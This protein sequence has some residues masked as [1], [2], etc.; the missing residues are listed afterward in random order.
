MLLNRL[1]L[2]AAN[3]YYCRTCLGRTRRHECARDRQIACLNSWAPPIT[4]VVYYEALRPLRHATMR[5][6]D[7]LLWGLERSLAW[8][9]EH[10][11]NRSR[12]LHERLAQLLK[13]QTFSN[14]V[15]PLHLRTLPHATLQRAPEPIH[16]ILDLFALTQPPCVTKP[17]CRRECGV[18]DACDSIALTKPLHCPLVSSWPQEACLPGKRRFHL[19][20]SGISLKTHR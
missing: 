13:I 20:A 19:L 2:Y 10:F 9:L 4:G 15:S 18:C 11:Y 1:N 16:L 5:P 17:L 3:P 12:L 14:T 6:S 8:I 7:I